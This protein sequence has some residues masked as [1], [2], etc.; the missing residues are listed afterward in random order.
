MKLSKIKEKAVG[1]NNKS[2][3]AFKKNAQMRHASSGKGGNVL[4]RCA[5]V[6]KDVFFEMKLGK[7]SGKRGCKRK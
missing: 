3:E 2:V 4:V 5:R 1:H 6:R 7:P